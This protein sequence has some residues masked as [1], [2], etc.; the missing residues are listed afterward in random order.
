MWQMQLSSNPVMLYTYLYRLPTSA[1]S[2]NQSNISTCVS[3]KPHSTMRYESIPAVAYR[4]GFVT[5]LLE[6][7]SCSSP[8]ASLIPSLAALLQD[9][10]AAVPTRSAVF[11]GWDSMGSPHLPPALLLCGFCWVLG[12]RSTLVS[13]TYTYTR[14][15]MYSYMYVHIYI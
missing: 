15:S 8:P 10:S 13:K 7:F 1:M 2:I 3:V 4:K 6:V 9:T 12:K 5:W 11:D 14:V